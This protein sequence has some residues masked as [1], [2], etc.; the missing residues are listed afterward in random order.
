M[1]V[2]AARLRVGEERSR[3]MRR[4]RRI[5]VRGVRWGFM[6]GKRDWKI[7]VVSVSRCFGM[8]F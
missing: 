1:P 8:G 2:P 7:D 6:E 4:T 5:E 3:L